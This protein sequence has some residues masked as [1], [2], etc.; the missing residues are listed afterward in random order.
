M[1]DV[2]IVGVGMTPVGEHWS[3]SLRTLA[4][5]A[6]LKAIKDANISELDALYVGNAFS[7]T[8]SSQTHL[9]ALIADQA[10][11]SGIEAIG[12]EAADASGGAAFRAG[13][14]AVA[15]GLVDTVAVVGVEKSTDAIAGARVESR[16]VGID[17]DY[18]SIH[19]ASLPAL[20]GML[21][22]RYMHEYEVELPAFEG[23]S[24]NAHNNGRLNPNAMFKNTLRQGAFSKAAMVANPVNLFDGAPDA[25]GAGAIILTANSRAVDLISQPIKVVGSAV[26]TDRFKI[27][28]RQQMLR[29]KAV[30]ISTQKALKQ[31]DLPLSDISFFELHDAF[32]ILTALSI[33]AIGLAEAGKGWELA[34]DHGKHIGL[35]GRTPISTFGGLKSRGNPIGAT[36]IYQI[37]ESVLQLQGRADKNQVEN[38]QVG[39]TQNIGG[40]GSTVITHLLSV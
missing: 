13:Y 15:S 35:S 18:E 28:D 30:N 34:S 4:A 17:A 21:M 16:N 22:R 12:I 6:L 37:I 11:I 38:A 19:G 9:G 25:D 26:A 31:A 40:L 14:L 33:E 36:G 27:Q 23:F 10:G 39:L 7:S 3:Q 29:L 8:F 24:I 1:R 2:S 5:D 32:T 20:A